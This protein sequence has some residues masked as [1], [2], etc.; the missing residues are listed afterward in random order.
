MP[1]KT[2]DEQGRLHANT[3]NV[4]ERK[5]I[6]GGVSNQDAVR[7]ATDLS[8]CAT[9]TL[10]LKPR[11]CLF[12]HRTQAPNR[13]AAGALLQL[14]SGVLFHEARVH[15]LRC[16]VWPCWR[17]PLDGLLISRPKVS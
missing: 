9:D 17:Q 15:Q 16:H 12:A 8:G 10:T 13:A 1:E 5:A 11:T 2:Q 7:L 14:T 3:I 4:R 6:A